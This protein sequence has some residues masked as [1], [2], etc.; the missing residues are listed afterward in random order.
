MYTSALIVE[1]AK[2]VSANPS[3]NEIFFI[4]YDGGEAMGVYSSEEDAKKILL[5]DAQ[6]AR[7]SAWEYETWG[8]VVEENPCEAVITR[9]SYWEVPYCYKD[10]SEFRAP[11]GSDV[12]R[13]LNLK[14]VVI[15]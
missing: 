8:V 10:K 1:V 13:I 7:E 2:L 4:E 12:N 5:E 6:K 14:K 11:E 3:L 9:L 15:K